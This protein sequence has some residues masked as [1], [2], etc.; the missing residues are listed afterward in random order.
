MIWSWLG[1]CFFTLMVALSMAEMCSAYPLSG[2][3]YSWA[4]VLAPRRWYRGF[5]YVCG[6]FMLIGELLGAE[7]DMPMRRTK[8]AGSRLT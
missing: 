1:V 6:W 3:Q 4:A 7:H 2:G 8:I 5:S